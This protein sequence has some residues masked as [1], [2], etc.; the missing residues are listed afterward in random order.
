MNL[1]NRNAIIALA[2]LLALAMAVVSFLAWAESAQVIDA[3]E[4]FAAYLREHDD[5][6]G[7]LV[8]TLAAL[9]VAVLSMLVIIL[10]LSPD[11]DTEAENLEIRGHGATLLAPRQAVAERL[12]DALLQLDGVLEAK[13]KPASKATDDLF[14]EA[15]MLVEAGAVPSAVVGM[16]VD[17]MEEALRRDLGVSLSS[18]SRIHV[19][20]ASGPRL[21]EALDMLNPPRAGIG[22]QA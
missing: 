14:V 19:M 10:E 1:G 13:V 5:N 18:D 4:D 11:T 20:P 21:N 7:R 8:V 15:E 22:D 12:Q 2:A 3:L 6:S 17:T 9:L 16:A